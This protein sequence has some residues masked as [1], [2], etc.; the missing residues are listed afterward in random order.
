MD[1][2]R[3]WNEQPVVVLD[4]ETTGPDPKTCEPLE[5]A[6]A[7]FEGGRCVAEYASLLL[8]DAP[9]PAAATAVHGI[10]DEMVGDKPKLVDVA[11]ELA[12]VCAGAIPCAY[13]APFDRT[14]L[15]RY[16]AG[17]DA[18]A[19]DP[20]VTWLDV[21]VVVSSPR[22]DKFVSGS[23]RLK[24][25]AVCK[26]WGVELDG[27]HRALADA[28]ATGA[29]LFR[30][31]ERGAIKSCTLDLLLEHM[32]KMREEQDAEHARFRRKVL[33]EDRA[34]WRQYACAALAGLV[35]R[36]DR[37]DARGLVEAAEEYADEMLARE[38]NRFVKGEG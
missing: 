26:R 10:T 27:A 33:A 13:N 16:V 22:V 3:P 36:A 29:L 20:T 28:K 12:K 21:Y 18:P 25:S 2:T 35:T 31:L 38:K 32:R 34:V 5:V 8:P 23:G 37:Y 15:H 19:F 9:I 6:A 7:R 17:N 1:L 14:V 11:G 24:L 4:F 30:L